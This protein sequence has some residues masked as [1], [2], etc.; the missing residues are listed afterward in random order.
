LIDITDGN[1]L[2]TTRNLF[3]NEDF[4]EVDYVD[5]RQQAYKIRLTR[6]KVFTEKEDKPA[7]FWNLAMKKVRYDT[8]SL[9]NHL[10]FLRNL[11][12]TQ[13]GNKYFDVKKGIV[14]KPA[15][16]YDAPM[17]LWPGFVASVME[18]QSQISFVVDLCYKIIR[19]GTPQSNHT[20][21]Q[22]RYCMG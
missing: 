7:L 15:S 14:T 21:K 22:Y 2:F 5:R 10:K 8:L 13:V 3:E 11:R 17:I 20:P 4:L 1:Q 16:R 18:N 19:Q 9:T 6:V 12:L